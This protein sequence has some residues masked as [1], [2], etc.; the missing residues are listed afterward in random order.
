MSKGNLARRQSRPSRGRRIVGC[1]GLI[2]VALLVVNTPILLTLIGGQPPARGE[3]VWLGATVLF[4]LFLLL[5][6]I[7]GGKQR[8]TRVEVRPESGTLVVGAPSSGGALSE[9]GSI[10]L[11]DVRAIS[12]EIPHGFSTDTG[13][14]VS[15][16]Y[17][18]RDVPLEVEIL[19]GVG[20]PPIPRTRLGVTPFGPRPAALE[21]LRGL[22]EPAGLPYIRVLRNDPRDFCIRAS[23]NAD[24]P[25]V[26]IEPTPEALAAARTPFDPGVRMPMPYTLREWKPGSRVLIRQGWDLSS[27]LPLLYSMAL[28]AVGLLL[29]RAS[30]TAEGLFGA[31]GDHV[32]PISGVG[33]LFVVWA[34]YTALPGHVL[35]DWT[36]GELVVRRRGRARRAR[37][38]EIQQ[39]ELSQEVHSLPRTGDSFGGPY[40][41]R[42]TAQARLGGGRPLE[43]LH[44]GNVLVTRSSDSRIRDYRAVYPM[45]SHLAD[46]L[47]VPLRLEHVRRRP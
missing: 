13:A 21:I 40:G 33:I 23:R 25:G 3:W 34:G 24:G 22:A 12:V 37:L 45:L 10:P 6:A 16:R 9:L 4:A 36:A 28:L 31:I 18:P 30:G 38:G 26:P 11:S 29:L 19:E 43:L 20:A 1:A 41:H 32:L 8:P 46:A 17:V 42:L 35:V 47:R 27:L 44:A 7:D 5:A 14:L 39:L 15:D 2:F